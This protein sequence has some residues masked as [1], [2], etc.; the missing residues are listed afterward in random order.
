MD[1]KK[2]G[3][4][5]RDR[6]KDL[7]LTQLEVAQYCGVNISTVSRW[8]TGYVKRMK[9]GEIEL[10]AKKLHCS[11]Q[12]LMGDDDAPPMEEANL[13]RAKEQVKKQIDGVQ[14][15]HTLEIILKIISADA[16]S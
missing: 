2:V 6:R 13:A 9:R 15:E 14:N 4:I 11:P 10:L 5:I 16:L 7:G 3:Q 8:E 12:T 1:D